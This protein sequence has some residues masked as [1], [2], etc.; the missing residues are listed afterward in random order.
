V[1]TLGLPLLEAMSHSIPVVAVQSEKQSATQAAFAREIC[2]DAA[3]Y[4]EPDDPAGFAAQIEKLLADPMLAFETGQKG[5]SRI[6]EISWEAHIQAILA[7]L[8]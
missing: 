3:L 6:S 5:L 8:P 2:A 4:A 1:E 7:D